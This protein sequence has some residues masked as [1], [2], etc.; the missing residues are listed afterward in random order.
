LE[1]SFP[2]KEKN[3]FHTGLHLTGADFLGEQLFF[4]VWGD[5]Q[6]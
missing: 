5:L 4:P 1:F 6:A 3:K 2:G